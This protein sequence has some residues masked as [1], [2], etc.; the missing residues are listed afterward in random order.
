M[1]LER[2]C[3]GF[4]NFHCSISI[5]KKEKVKDETSKKIREINGGQIVNGHFDFLCDKKTKEIEKRGF[6]NGNS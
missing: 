1:E 5:C 6:Q 2:T 3:I 4:T